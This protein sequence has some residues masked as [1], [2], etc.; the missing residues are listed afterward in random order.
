MDDD[1]VSVPQRTPAM[2]TFG[3]GRFV[4]CHHASR[5][6]DGVEYGYL[7]WRMQFPANGRIWRSFNMNGTGDNTVQVFPERRVVVVITTTN[8]NVPQPHKRVA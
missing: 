2:P 5:V 4:R 7:W 8:H 6:D 1:D 3:H